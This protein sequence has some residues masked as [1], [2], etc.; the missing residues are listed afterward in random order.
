[1]QSVILSPKYQVVIPKT[2]REALKLRPARKCRLSNMPDVLNLYR[3][4]ISK[5]SVDFSRAS[6]LNSNERMIECEYRR[7]FRRRFPLTVAA[8]CN[9]SSPYPCGS[10]LRVTGKTVQVRRGPAAVTGDESRLMPLSAIKDGKAR[11]V[12]RSGSQKTCPQIVL[13]VMTPVERGSGS[14]L[15]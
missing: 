6:I 2:V 13:L 9:M 1:M 12:G 7:H 15:N 5:N 8:G 3:N 10:P 4:A 11:R 14:E